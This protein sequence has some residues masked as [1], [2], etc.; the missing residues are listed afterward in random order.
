MP[1]V[2]PISGIF[3]SRYQPI[4]FTDNAASAMIEMEMG[5]QYIGDVIPVKS[6]FCQGLVQGIV[7]MQIIMT[8][9]F[10]ILFVADAIVYEDKALAFLDQQ[11]AHSPGTEIV[12]IG[13]MDFAP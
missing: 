11:A 10:R 12:L 4:P 3:K 6:M 2:A 8:E 13:R 5:Q 1:L 7:T 9:K